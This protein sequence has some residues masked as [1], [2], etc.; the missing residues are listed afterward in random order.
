M[1]RLEACKIIQLL[2]TQLKNIS[3]AE[4]IIKRLE[5]IFQIDCNTIIQ[6]SIHQNLYY[7]NEDDYFL[8]N[9]LTEIDCLD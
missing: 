4:S 3:F 6:N 1:V 9:E 2:C 8:A 7:E 5:I